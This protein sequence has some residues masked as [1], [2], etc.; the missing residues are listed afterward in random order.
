M[1]ADV[2]AIEIDVVGIGPIIA[3]H[4][5]SRPVQGHPDGMRAVGRRRAGEARVG[6]EMRRQADLLQPPDVRGRV[7]LDARLEHGA[8][9]VAQ[10]EQ[11]TACR[12]A[13]KAA[14]GVHERDVL[15]V[16]A[17]P[18]K[19]LHRDRVG[20]DR[21]GVLVRIPEG[22]IL[23]RRRAEQADARS[24][25]RIARVGGHLEDRSAKRLAG[26]RGRPVT[27]QRHIGGQDDRRGQPI[28]ADRKPERAATGPAQQARGQDDRLRGVLVLR[29]VDAEIGDVVTGH[30]DVARRQR[31]RDLMP[32]HGGTRE[33]MSAQHSGSKDLQFVDRPEVAL[34]LNP[35]RNRDAQVAAIPGRI[36]HDVRDDRA[37]ACRHGIPLLAVGG[38]RELILARI[39]V[40]R[41]RRIQFYLGDR[42]AL[43]HVDLV[44]LAGLFRAARVPARVGIA[45]DGQRGMVGEIAR[46]HIPQQRIDRLI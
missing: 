30:D 15:Q 38:N 2:V 11:R 16:H 43:A 6:P 19:L 22:D 4:D 46:G 40:G 28:M 33:H 37:G 18:A 29:R 5:N 21:R 26:L 14:V 12:P 34:R 25:L 45:V 13:G 36:A 41:G 42:S 39:I 7:D 3:A 35:G 8:V 10:E 20:N 32:V 17:R 31:R 9:D 44:P 1:K 24:A 27:A 23:H